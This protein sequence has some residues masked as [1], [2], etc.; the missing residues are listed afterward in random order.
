MNKIINFLKGLFLVK[1]TNIDRNYHHYVLSDKCRKKMSVLGVKYKDLNY[2]FKYGKF[3]SNEM[4]DEIVLE[5]V[6]YLPNEIYEKLS[7]SDMKHFS[8]VL[9]LIVVIKPGTKIVINLF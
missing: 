1:T 6:N 3:K 5:S 7:N 2:C 8:E 4:Y 9:P